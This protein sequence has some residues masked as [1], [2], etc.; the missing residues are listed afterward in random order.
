VSDDIVNLPIRSDGRIKFSS[1]FLAPRG[2]NNHLG[3]DFGAQ[4]PGVPRDD[5][6]AAVPGKLIFRGWVKKFGNIFPGDTG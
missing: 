2:N 1:P 5:V 4:T 3:T 6:V